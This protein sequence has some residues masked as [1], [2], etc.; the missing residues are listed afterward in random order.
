[1]IE[2][3][4]PTARLHYG[5]NIEISDDG[6]GDLDVFIEASLKHGVEKSALAVRRLVDR[7]R[8]GNCYR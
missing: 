5:T 4:L 1:M 6:D 8:N 3:P 2:P 7:G